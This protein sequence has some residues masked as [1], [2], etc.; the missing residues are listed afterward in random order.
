MSWGSHRT[1]VPWT[2]LNLQCP[3][4][5]SV[6]SNLIPR[7]CHHFCQFYESNKAETSSLGGPNTSQNSVSKSHFFPSIWRAELGIAWLHPDHAMLHQGVGEAEMSKNA[8]NVPNIF[9][10]GSSFREVFAW[11]MQ[12]LNWFLGFPQSVFGPSTGYLVLLSGKG[13]P[14]AFLPTVLADDVTLEFWVM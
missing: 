1:I 13:G 6:A 12:L 4:S 8:I 2:S 10:C 9:E 5:L 11:L 14:E 3:P 7:L